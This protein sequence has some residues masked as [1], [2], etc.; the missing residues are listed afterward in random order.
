MNNSSTCLISDKDYSVRSGLLDFEIQSTI[1]DYIKDTI[2]IKSIM[3][4]LDKN[5][6]IGNRFHTFVYFYA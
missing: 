2:K 6:L 1:N 4:S 5:L 3:K